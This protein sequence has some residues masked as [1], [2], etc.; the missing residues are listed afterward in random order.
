MAEGR[1]RSEWNRT[2]HVLAWVQNWSGFAETSVS[3]KELNPCIGE[4]EIQVPEIDAADLA[5]MVCGQ[6][7]I[8][9]FQQADQQK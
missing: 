9:A 2:S 1:E 4:D 6:L 8:D 3:P 7:A 5:V